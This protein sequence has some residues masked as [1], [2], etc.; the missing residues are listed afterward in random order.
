MDL[1]EYTFGVTLEG[2]RKRINNI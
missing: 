1:M 2:N